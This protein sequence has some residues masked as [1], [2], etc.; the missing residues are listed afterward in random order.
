MQPTS[1]I[2]DRLARLELAFIRIRR[3]WDAPWLRRRVLERVGVQVDPSLVRTLHA[4]RQA[5]GDTAVGDAAAWLCVDASTASRMVDAAVVAGYLE[6]RRSDS[7]RR[8]SV[9]T[10]TKTGNQL[11]DRVLATRRELLAELT[12][13]WSDRDVELFTHLMERLARRVAEVEDRS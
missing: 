3:L 5:E 9:V 4:V 12:D 13:D 10:L 2:S 7:D 6:R 1:L 8:R 11:L